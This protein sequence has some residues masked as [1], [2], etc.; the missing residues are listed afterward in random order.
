MLLFLVLENTGRES[1]GTADQDQ[2]VGEGEKPADDGTQDIG[3]DEQ[4]QDEDDDEH[5]PAFTMREHKF[6]FQEFERVSEL[7]CR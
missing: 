3:G 6:H 5:G 4:D 7:T 1:S 2:A